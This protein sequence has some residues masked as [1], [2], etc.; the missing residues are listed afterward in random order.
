MWDCI[1]KKGNIDIPAIIFNQGI[2]FLPIIQGY[3]R[4]QIG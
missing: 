3:A 2:K 4:L 1:L